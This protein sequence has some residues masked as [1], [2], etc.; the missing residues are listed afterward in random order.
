MDPNSSLGIICLGDDVIVIS[1]DIVEGSGDWNSP[2]YQDTAGSKGKKAMSA[3]SFYMVKKGNKVVKKELIVALKGELYFVKFSINQEE[4]DVEPRVILGRP[5]MR[6]AKGIVD[7]DNG[8]ITIYPELDPFED[9]S[10]KEVKSP[11]DWDQLLDFNFD[12]VPNGNNHHWQWKL[13]LA[14]GTLNLAVGM[15]CAFYS[16]QFGEELPSLVCKTRKS[17][18][19]KKRSM[20]NLSSFYQDIR[21]SLSAGG[22]L[23]LEEAAT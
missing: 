9:D 6:L 19:N 14:E 8:V 2:K 20:E 1:S 5:F 22:H 16:Q 12:N 23:T 4:D 11:D 7:F 17:N 13:I 3:L 10:E 18:H 15:P 21:P